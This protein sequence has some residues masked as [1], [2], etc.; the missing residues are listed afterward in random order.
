MDQ[1]PQQQPS[2]PRRPARRAPRAA[3]AILAALALLLAAA[4]A[5]LQTAPAREAL[6]RALARALAGPGP[7]RVEISGLGPGLPGTLALE[8][9]TLA[10]ANGTWL[11]VEDLEVR[12]SPWRLLAGRLAMD[13]LRVRRIGVQRLP[14]S[15]EAALPDRPVAKP[16]PGPRG[17]FSLPSLR[18]R[19]LDIGELFVAAAVTGRDVRLGVRSEAR[20]E[21]GGLVLAAS[22]SSLDNR[23]DRFT[24]RA[25]LARDLSALALDLALD[26]A[27]GGV[28][29]WTLGFSEHIPLSI[30]LSGQGPARDWR[31]A[32]NATAPGALAL[33]AGLSLAWS[34]APALRAQGR[35][36]LAPALA[37]ARLEDL[38]RG[39]VDFDLVA[40]PEAD[41]LVRVDSLDLRGPRASA[42]LSGRV[43]VLDLDLDARGRLILDE[44]AALLA[45]SGFAVRGLEPLD[46]FARGPIEHMDIS[47]QA[48]AEE[49]G[50]AGLALPRPLLDLSARSLKGLFC[51]DPGLT[52]NATLAGPGL[53]LRGRPL[54][55]AP[56]LAGR[57]STADFADLAFSDA[58]FL[59]EGLDLELDGHLDTATL[60]SRA[61][62]RLGSW[63]GRS[64]PAAGP[65]LPLWGR[66]EAEV[67]ADL[68]RLSGRAEVAGELNGLAG[69][70]PVL[71]AL[72]KA[73]A[74]FSGR[75]EFDRSRLRATGFAARSSA[76]RLAGR[77]TW[78]WAAGSFQVAADL[79]AAD[80]RPLG[81]VLGLDLA[82]P[83]GLNATAFGRPSDF[84]ARAEVRVHGL[85]L[86]GLDLG[87][88]RVAADL[89]SLPG[90]PR[91]RL[92]LAVAPQPGR[93]ELASG[94]ESPA[95]R[96]RL[97]D[98]RGQAPGLS[99]S[100]DLDLDASSL[101][102]TGR[103]VGEVRAPTL[104]LGDKTR[105]AARFGLDLAAQNSTQAAVLDLAARK[106]SGPDLRLEVLDLRADLT[107]LWGRVRGQA[108]LTGRGFSLGGLVLDELAAGLRGGLEE[109]EFDLRGRG[110]AGRPL[111]ILA[112]GRAERGPELT[113]LTL[114]SLSGGWD[115]RPIA[116]AGPAT[117]EFSADALAVDGLDLAVAGGRVRAG[118][119][120][121]TRAA[122][123]TVSA[124]DL[125]LALAGFL[126]PLPLTGLA[127]AELH[128]GG[129][130]QNPDLT[131]DFTLRQLG[132]A[133]G[134][135]RPGPLGLAG[136]ARL[137]AG[138]L[139]VRA[140]LTG[141]GPERL[142]LAAA[143]P[144]RCVLWP[145]LVDFPPDGQLTGAAHGVLD[146]AALAR[147]ADLE[148]R[149][150]GG[151]A[152]IDLDL[153]GTLAEP[154]LAGRIGL[155]DG[156]FENALLGVRVKDV[157]AVLEARG[158]RVEVGS[159]AGTD[160]AAGRFTGTGALAVEPGRG[161]PFD[162]AL[163]LVKMQALRRDDV[164][165]TASGRAV[166]AGNSTAATL[167][168]DL[169]LDP[170]EAHIPDRL[171]REIAELSISEVNADPDRQ[172]IPPAPAPVLALSLDLGLDIPGRFFVRGR[173]L[174][175]EFRGRVRI[176][177]RPEAAAVSGALGVVRGRYEFLDRTFAITQGSLAFDGASAMPYLNVRGE[178]ATADII[179]RALL[180]G[181]AK[182]F[183]L[184]LES[185]PPLPKDE[186]LARLLFGR[187]TAALNPVQA[188]QLANAVRRL[189]LGG[190]TLDPTA[191][192]RQALGLDQLGVVSGQGEKGAGL[193]MG[194]YLRDN[195]YIEVRQDLV[196]GGEEV[197][198]EVDLAPNLGVESTTGTERSGVGLHWKKDY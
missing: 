181:P 121:A 103:I 174:D 95:G 25:A 171:P 117:L 86:A 108:R 71:A 9:L 2:P 137:H 81:P 11:T 65:R 52:A 21:D 187:S 148:G 198:L 12:W 144:A 3:A 63:E 82:G 138:A 106:F 26:E 112:R 45:G 175:A 150:L 80:S 177:G 196:K 153:S 73:G 33:H 180:V 35:V 185:D 195:V 98:I 111:D 114:E 126:L 145:W 13:A 55:A 42:G 129:A 139:A 53:L 136:A 163:S 100:G 127:D 85:G 43:H 28:L 96:L 69:L 4:W 23:P 197:T 67:A 75:V 92:S 158:K 90:A 72:A 6:A 134:A 47:L 131:L 38:W 41:G 68:D 61:R 10:D 88:A 51:R 172:T 143:L 59:A 122:D 188:A 99:L 19:Q 169:V 8:R 167:S 5:A 93:V 49:L 110:L 83:L 133:G 22:A 15:G 27:P 115:G 29:G 155:H 119:R 105:G 151:R 194:K 168:G 135:S 123:L 124:R 189:T 54:A 102:A 113:R 157:E 193:S 141:L 191:A 130:A 39:G 176:T 152:E 66:A 182:S 36:V 165:L 179:A 37:P 79:S 125:P 40:R 104:L 18:I 183:S 7:A 120:V 48:R 62:V 70:H 192:I 34:G 170:V 74:S 78:E 184:V 156:R 20:L 94:L 32:L 16:A 190:P 140:A 91:G 64:F 44:P 24:L 87:P 76:A 147:L 30:A 97:T 58:R 162:L 118:G 166:L 159:L 116:L 107:D 17:P 56:V 154:A 77:G 109:A 149:D 160:G 84:A 128:A 186:I 50:L 46:I 14:G 60:A 173:G 161:F 89:S 164:S 142:E 132:A 101:L 57:M 31:G 1:T 178:S 146:P